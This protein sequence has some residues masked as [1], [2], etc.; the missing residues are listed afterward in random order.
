MDKIK[1]RP[2]L[3]LEANRNSIAVPHVWSFILKI[4]IIYT[5]YYQV[6]LESKFKCNSKCGILWS[7]HF[8][9]Q[10]QASKFMQMVF[11]DQCLFV[12]VS[13]PYSPMYE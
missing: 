1:V 7:A 6:S 10:S 8:I 11:S 3:Y 13:V 5:V 12:L 9:C 4:C 2:A